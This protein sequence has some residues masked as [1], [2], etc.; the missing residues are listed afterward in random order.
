MQLTFR[1]MPEILVDFRIEKLSVIL[2]HTSNHDHYLSSGQSLY[3]KNRFKYGL[4]LGINYGYLKSRSFY[5]SMD[6][7]RGCNNGSICSCNHGS[8]CGCIQA[9]PE[10]CNCYTLHRIAVI[11]VH[12]IT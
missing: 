9:M 3:S 11:F 5:L 4:R 6:P 7:E 2:L 12:I 1:N 10:G 8:S